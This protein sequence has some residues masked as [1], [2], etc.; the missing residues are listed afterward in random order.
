MASHYDE[1][2]NMKPE[3]FLFVCPSKEDIDIIDN[4]NKK[5]NRP[6]TTHIHAS[7]AAELEQKKRF[8]MRI[9]TRKVT[10][11][12]KLDKYY[13]MIRF[14]CVTMGN[15]KDPTKEDGEGNGEGDD[16]IKPVTAYIKQTHRPNLDL[17]EIYDKLPYDLIYA[18]YNLNRSMVKLSGL[19][20]ESRMCACCT[21]W[22]HSEDE[23]IIHCSSEPDPTLEFTADP[24]S[25]P[26][27]DLMIKPISRELI[28]YDDGGDLLTFEQCIALLQ[29]EVVTDDD[30]PELVP[31][32][33]ED[34]E[35]LFQSSV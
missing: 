24:I 18:S 19:Y 4:Y 11:K 30:L 26:E 15:T 22:C 16:Q 23:P 34:E 32:S 21:Q 2:I 8:V 17:T 25:E 5:N 28:P 27:L 20:P 10:P 31:Y 14:Y 33:D 29:P 13:V 6:G 35:I 9:I 7:F 1:I 3:G 12:G